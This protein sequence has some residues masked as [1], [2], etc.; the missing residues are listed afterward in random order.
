[1]KKRTL[2]Y[3]PE[4]KR[5]VCETALSQTIRK[6]A[7]LYGVNK[8]TVT[9]WLKTYKKMLV[10]VT[11][12]DTVKTD[13][14]ILYIYFDVVASTFRSGSYYNLYQFNI[15]DGPGTITTIG[16]A[17]SKDNDNIC[18][19]LDYVLTTLKEM[20][21]FSVKEIRTNI[22]Y[23]AQKGNYTIYKSS[24]ENKFGVKLQIAE[25]RSFGNKNIKIEAGSGTGKKE[26]I[27]KA[28]KKL[29]TA[30]ETEKLSDGILM[31]PLFI[32]DFIKDCDNILSFSNYWNVLNLPEK[33]S[34]ILF[35]VIKQVEKM[36]DEAKI[37]FEFDKAM[38]FYHR[39][40][41][42]VPENEKSADMRTGTMIKQAEIYY[43]LDNLETSK[44]LLEDCLELSERH[45]CVSKAAKAQYYL[46][47]IEYLMSE[48]SK[49][50][51]HFVMAI[52]NYEKAGES[53]ASFDYIQAK[54]RKE[55]N[56]G[57][58]GQAV[59]IIDDFII[60]TSSGGIT[61][62]TAKAY[63]LKGTALYM[64]GDFE[65]TEK[66]YLSQL[67]IAEELK[68]HNEIALSLT[69]LVTLYGYL[70]S[71]TYSELCSLLKRIKDISHLTR[72]K[73]Y[74]AESNFALG[75]YYFRKNDHE[76]AVRHLHI[77]LSGLKILKHSY[78]YS[79]NLYFLG[80][81][82]F[83]NEKYLRSAKLFKELLLQENSG[84]L[85]HALDHLGMIYF[86]RENWRKAV[87]YFKKTISSVNG[88]DQ[89]YFKATAFKHLGIIYEVHRQVPK[90]ALKYYLG[91]KKHFELHQKIDPDYDIS[92]QLAFLNQKI[93]AEM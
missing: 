27:A 24:I 91:S 84:F 75:V 42:T 74:S 7:D 90:K 34:S 26:I 55:M 32:D 66:C 38:D 9:R 86:K 30:Q 92:E 36:A 76:K 72:K 31:P 87:F 22:Y 50:D 51:R 56:T 21:R 33:Q 44:E 48:N 39:I 2:K 3:T 62:F 16:F 93:N 85:L 10:T 19:F 28:Y 11:P 83:L 58:T 45:N 81:S 6:A 61:S 5:E 80:R 53:P 37:E 46:G 57:L 4:F 13:E 68:D 67:R 12:R 88:N 1:M 64:K 59:N 8:E 40:Y 35:E 15:Y 47:M 77:S 60:K 43:H 17:A 14:C 41:L 69:C 49:A 82:L 71:K 78:K 20:N 73:T 23:L 54:V 65:G 70:D 52:A 79:S 29:I 25:S 18:L 89:H 63:G